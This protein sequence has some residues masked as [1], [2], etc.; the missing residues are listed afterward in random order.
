VRW[1]RKSPYI[2]GVKEQAKKEFPILGNRFR[3]F[4]NPQ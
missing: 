1:K 3:P 4:L 2:W